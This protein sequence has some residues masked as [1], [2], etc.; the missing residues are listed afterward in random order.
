MCDARVLSQKGAAIISRCSE[1]RCI[2]IWNH[3]VILS[4]SPQQFAL[5]KGFVD[6]MVFEENAFP[7]PDGEDRAMMRTPVDN[8][9]LTFTP[10]EWEDF[11]SAIG[12]AIYMQEI[13]TMMEGD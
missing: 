11:Q 10:T 8:I 3:N 9:Q 5:F 7:F 13:Y 1:C 6:D 4:F 12:E 2:F